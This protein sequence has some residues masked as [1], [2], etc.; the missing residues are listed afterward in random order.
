VVLDPRWLL[1]TAAAAGA[2]VLHS[3]ALRWGQ[4]AVVQPL[5]VSGL[6][7]ALPVAALLER[8]RLHLVHLGWSAAV[9]GGLALFLAA[10]RPALG[11]PTAPT[12][13][14]G[15]AVGIVL[16]LAV[17]SYLSGLRRRRHRAALWAL[18]G[19]LGYGVVAALLKQDI[20]LLDLGLR[21]VLTSWAFYALLLVGPASVAVNQAAFNA[22]ALVSSLPTLTMANPVAAI[23]IGAVVFGERVASAPA[24]VAGQVLGFAVMALGVVALTASAPQPEPQRPPG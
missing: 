12:S 24:L 18:A 19:G 20:G 15:P 3:L 2:F 9:V 17:G 8:R 7:L 11:R 14:L 13:T 10:A 6:V 4:L 16:A 22:G 21:H 23:A 5:L 1:G